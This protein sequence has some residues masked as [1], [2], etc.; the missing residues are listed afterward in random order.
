MDSRLCGN[1][2]TAQNSNWLLYQSLI[3]FMFL[4]FTMIEE[5]KFILLEKYTKMSGNEIF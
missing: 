3:L 1:D 2:K 5:Q 4:L